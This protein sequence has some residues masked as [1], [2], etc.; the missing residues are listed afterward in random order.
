MTEEEKKKLEEEAAAAQAAQEESTVAQAPADGGETETPAVVEQG[1]ETPAEN[2]ETPAEATEQ[3]P[4][5]RPNY[6]AVRNRFQEAYPDD[7]YS[8]D[9]ALMGRVNSR[10]DELHSEND[11]YKQREEEMSQFF[12][13]D[14]RNS[15]LLSE[16]KKGN[17]LLANAAN[18]YYDEWKAFMDDPSEE[19]LQALREAEQNHIKELAAAAAN[20]KE[21]KENLKRSRE[22]C[23]AKRKEMNMSEE[24]FDQTMKEF[25][26]LATDIVM[27]IFTP[28]TL[29]FIMKGKNY[30]KD[31]ES[32]AADAEL[33]GRTANIQEKKRQSKGS[34][35]PMGGNG[36]TARQSDKP[37]GMQDE[38]LNRVKEQEKNEF[39]K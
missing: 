19:N 10:L 15:Y 31:I 7:D 33:K 1:A 21:Y 34:G 23:E 29:D 38:F 37:Q 27:G 4:A 28:E 6:D 5:G 36:G 13:G 32:A 8:D 20:D 22:A 39:W 2:A 11:G 3:T 26:A 17:G 14:P 18:L 12:T 30:D 16:W 35:L 9:E 25:E 24:E